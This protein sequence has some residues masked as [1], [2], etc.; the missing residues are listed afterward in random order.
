MN[1]D[2]LTFVS[3]DL[4]QG[5]KVTTANAS[6]NNEKINVQNMSGYLGKSDVQMNGTISNYMGYMFAENQSL[7]GTMNVTSNRFNVNEWMVDEYS[8]QPVA[9]QTSTEATGVV[10]VPGNIDFVLNSSVKEV[11]Y[12]NL[13]L[14][15]MKGAVII[16]DK[17]AKLQNLAFNTLGAAFVTNGSYNTQSLAHPKFTFDLD[18]KNLEFKEAFNAFETMQK[19]API[20]KF[21]E[22]KFSTNFAFAGELGQDMMPVMGTMTGKGVIEVVRAVVKNIK[23]LNKIGETTNFKEVQN[24]II[25]NKDI[26]AEILN[27]NLVVK[28]FDI[29]VGDLNMT[30]GGTNNLSGGIDY[31]VA[32]DVPTG[33]VGSALNNKLSSFAGMK[34]YKGA[35]RVT[36]NLKVGGTM[37]DPKVGLAGGSAKAQAKDMV[38]DVVS[39]RLNTEKEKLNVKRQAAQ[40]S[41]QR[42]VDRRKKEAEEKARQELEKKRKEAEQKLQN[43]AKDKL[44]GLFGK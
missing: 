41:L 5:M 16:K 4:P 30:V 29:K 15:N 9:Q 31:G 18:I 10:E 32:M 37:E 44:K 43:Q 1:V 35:E 28:P 19:L 26:A 20:S 3:K 39:S 34:D 17:T 14:Q 22:G 24:F 25:E 6:F 2:K 36:L 40:D 12:D 42:E 7:R 38:K 13:K 33:K 21:L 8:G 23:V 27:G 11:L